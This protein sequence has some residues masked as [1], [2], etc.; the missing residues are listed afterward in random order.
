MMGMQMT[1][2]D[3]T[4]FLAT[5][6]FGAIG[7]RAFCFGAMDSSQLLMAKI[8]RV[9]RVFKRMMGMQMTS[10]DATISLGAI[11]F[12]AMDSSQLLMAFI[13]RVSRVWG[14]KGASF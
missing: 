7:F 1:R 9:S 13:L 3:G 2:S 10:G 12:G 14:R 4:N 6:C 5:I 11:S 8:L